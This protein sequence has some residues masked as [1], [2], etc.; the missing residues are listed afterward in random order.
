MAIIPQ[1]RCSHFARAFD[2]YTKI[3]DFEYVEGDD[4]TSAK[5]A[6]FCV[7]LDQTWVRASSTLKTLT[8]TACVLHRSL[9]RSPER[10][11]PP[12]SSNLRQLGESRLVIRSWET[13]SDV[14]RGRR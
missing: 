14:D 13:A 11:S 6:A 1:I 8:A 3:L 4:P 9:K 7:P 5:D 10:M 2:F 12:A